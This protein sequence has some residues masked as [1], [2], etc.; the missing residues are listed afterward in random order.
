MIL[1]IQQAGMFKMATSTVL[2]FMQKTAEDE[3]LRQQLEDLLGV[4]DGNISSATELDAAESEAL[5]GERAPV[6][7]D[8]AAKNGFQFSVDELIT[9]VDAFQKYQTGA[10]SEI[11]F[12]KLIGITTAEKGGSANLASANKPLKRL[13]R[14]LSKTYLGIDLPDK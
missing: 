1:A 9:V 6:V 4:G 14:Y 2:E 12:G 5:K 11:D 10:M 8:F 7:T 13:T 3:T